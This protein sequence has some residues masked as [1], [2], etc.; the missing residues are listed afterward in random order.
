MAT[1]VT[2]GMA[3]EITVPC[4]NNEQT[5]INVFHI[6]CQIPGPTPVTDADV[7]N[8]FDGAWASGWRGI[9]GPNSTYRG[10]GCRIMFGVPTF[11][12]QVSGSGAGAGLSGTTDLP[13]QATGIT[14]WKTDRSGR[15][16]RGRTYWPFPPAVFDT[17]DGVPL[18][19]YVTAV[20]T[21]ADIYSSVG[22]ISVGPR[23]STFAAVLY[24]RAFKGDPTHVPPIP[25]RAASFDFITSYITRLKW[26]T[27]RR[28][29]SYGRANPPP[30]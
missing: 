18:G 11:G 17:G 27:Q 16:E 1:P 19:I 13:R 23:S 7:A 3:L 5:S 22:V 10:T 6:S 25:P 24:H 21:I 28:R 15:A 9:L 29:G 20:K 12:M 30:F 14:S 26:A 4:T 8:W 2:T